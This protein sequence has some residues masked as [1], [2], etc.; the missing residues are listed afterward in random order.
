MS[1]NMS[2]KTEQDHLVNTADLAA[3]AQNR[4]TGILKNALKMAFGTMTSRVLGLVRESLLSALFDKHITDAW[5]IAF[6]VPNMFR[7]LLG[8]GSLSVSF[9]PVFIEAEKESKARSQNLVNSLYT[10]LLLVLTV[11]T[12][13][14]VLCPQLFLD[15]ALDPSYIANTEKYQLT[16]HMARIMFLFIFFITSFAFFMGILNSL[17]QFFWP[18]IA[19]TFWNLAMVISTVW[20]KSWL[21]AE[22]EKFGD[23]LAWGVVIG[24]LFQAA[25]LIPSLVKSGYFPKFK[26]DFKNKDMHTVLKKMLPGIVG[27]GLLQ[28][29]TIANV[30]FASGF[31]EGTVS[32]M[33]YVDR[34]IELPLS[35]I[36]VSLGT[37]LL[38]ALSKLWTDQNKT[39]MAQ[40][41]KKYLELNLFISMAAA[42][43]LYALAEPIIQLLFGRGHF[44]AEDVF[45]SAQILK[46]YCWIM[47]F[48]SGVRV[49]TPAYYAVKNTWFPMSCSAAALGL[50]LLM[51]PVLISHF[52]VYGLMMSTI[53]SAAVNMSLLLFCYQLFICEFSYVSFFKS[54]FKFSVVAI[55]VYFAACSFFIIKEFLPAGFIGLLSGLLI[56]AI[57]S[58]FVFV[59][60]AQVLGVDEIRNL[61]RRFSKR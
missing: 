56:S 47:I 61:L 44:K 60:A 49:L 11:L 38:P 2:D 34:L 59:G 23:Q 26:F 40:T 58:L 36:S 53:I 28:F 1:D 55:A 3:Q 15:L 17:G 30:R 7:R 48:V 27:T 9:I 5:N 25:V 46:T 18:A 13:V 54:V 52:Q 37:A 45:A 42:A 31:Q 6:R 57:I 50:H 8:E 16:L 10:V 43:G 4:N 29:M 14:G 19:P 21:S 41:S 35:L 20:P 51:A 32:F 22:S 33:N 12:T 24:G 39:V